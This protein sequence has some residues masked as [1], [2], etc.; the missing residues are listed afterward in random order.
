MQALSTDH[1]GDTAVDSAD[2]LSRQ[3]D[4]FVPKPMGGWAR[5]AVA[6]A[7]F[8]SVIGALAVYHDA[9]LSSNEIDMNWEGNEVEIVD[10]GL[11]RIA[12]TLTNRAGRSVIIKDVEVVAAGAELVRVELSRSRFTDQALS[13]PVAL[14]NFD[15]TSGSTS[16]N[17]DEASMR[18]VF[19]LEPQDCS[20]H[21]EATEFNVWAIPRFDV[22]LADGVFQ[23][24][25]QKPISNPRFGTVFRPLPDVH[26]LEQACEAR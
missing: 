25:D 14:D 18:V 4:D 22:E 19:W 13:F 24:L 15:W 1:P 5:F 8:A 3:L 21:G 9:Q 17:F 20:D 26:P 12:G 7:L 10:G 2:Q 6:V 11:V 16:D 23:G